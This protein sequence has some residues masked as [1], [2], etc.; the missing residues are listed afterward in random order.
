MS[1]APPKPEP[2]LY[3]ALAERVVDVLHQHSVEAL[4]IG[5]YALA[6]HNYLRATDDL[7]LGVSTPI[8]KLKTIRDDLEQRG[9]IAALRT[10]DGNDPLGGVID[11]EDGSGALV[12]I[13][14]FDNSPAHG[15]PR[16]IMDA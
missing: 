3:I 7:D 16:A 11:V 14:N 9:F 12:Q 13:V 6:A 4:V 2:A 10:P 8:A 1:E 15:F 5:G